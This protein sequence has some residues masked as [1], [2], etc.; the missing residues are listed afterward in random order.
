LMMLGEGVA[1][2]VTIALMIAF[3]V[4]L[5]LPIHTDAV[6]RYPPAH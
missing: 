2:G 6:E 4:R 5:A 3:A 1:L